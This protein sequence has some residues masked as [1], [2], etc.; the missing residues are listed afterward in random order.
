MKDLVIA[1]RKIGTYEHW[2]EIDISTF[3]F[4]GY[5]PIPNLPFEKGSLIVAYDAGFMLQAKGLAMDNVIQ[6]DLIETL[7][8]LPKYEYVIDND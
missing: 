7:K 8:D 6:V 1:G 5:D 3:S 4:L 2:D